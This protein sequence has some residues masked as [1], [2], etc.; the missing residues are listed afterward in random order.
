MDG[1]KIE[2]LG[3]FVVYLLI[4]GAEIAFAEA[5][6]DVNVYSKA[7]GTEFCPWNLGIFVSGILKGFSHHGTALL[8]N[9]TVLLIG[10]VL[11]LNITCY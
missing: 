10:Q 5:E 6:G 1:L 2:I 8:G 7:R 3:F 4:E 11:L 9:H